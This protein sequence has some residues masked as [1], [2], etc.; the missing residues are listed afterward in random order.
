MKRAEMLRKLLH[1]GALAIPFGIAWLP[2]QHAIAFLLPLAAAMA[3]CEVLR[4]HWGALQR[5]FLRIFGSFLRPAEKGHF[6][7][8]T[9]FVMGGLIC[10]LVY[11]KPIAYTATAFL[12]VG[13]AA[14]SL[15]GM[16]FGRIRVFSGKSLE[17]TA[18][19]IAACLLFWTLFPQTG[20]GMALA[21]AILTGVLE[22][23]PLRV[24]DNFAVPLVCGLI[25]QTWTGW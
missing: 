1:L 24:N 2:R 21:A 7:G 5:T 9:W 23:A 3:A 12:V 17:G 20:F 6:T 13:D 15:V 8:A 4:L 16:H 11:E 22:L 25:L 14:A 18:A 10:A 19:C